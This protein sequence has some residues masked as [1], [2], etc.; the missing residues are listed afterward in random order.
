MSFVNR[1]WSAIMKK[2]LA[3]MF[4]GFFIS[5]SYN[6]RDN[7]HF[8]KFVY[9]LSNSSDSLK[10]NEWVTKN[11][12]GVSSENYLCKDSIRIDSV[13]WGSCFYRDK[14]YSVYGGCRGEFGGSL[15][16]VDEN[17]P[18]YVYYLLSTCAQMV[19][20]RGTVFY[21]TE[22]LAHIDGFGKVTR[23]DDPKKLVKIRRDSLL[24]PWRRE[25]FAHLNGNSVYEKLTYKGHALIDTVGATFD[26][27]FESEK[28]NYL[29]YSGYKATYLGLYNEHKITVLDTL[30][31]YQSYNSEKPGEILDG[32]YHYNYSSTHGVGMLEIKSSGDI[33]VKN[34]TIII[35]F[36][37]KETE[38]LEMGKPVPKSHEDLNISGTYKAD[39]EAGA[40]KGT[41]TLERRKTY[42]FYEWSLISEIG[43]LVA[44]QSAIVDFKQIPK[45]QDE[46]EFTKAHALQ[47]IR[48]YKMSGKEIVY[49]LITNNSVMHY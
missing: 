5:C 12:K 43:K 10:F 26:L 16:F 35:G 4:L 11:I 24:L 30:M 22:S 3:V 46:F 27:F 1:D 19:E 44:G 25:R 42:M 14:N 36:R 17:N 40:F 13:L 34:D 21:I 9:D 28:N 6:N 8:K 38:R 37:Y 41:L 32:I 48:E 15:I 47:A 7:K 18:S 45:G 20:R 39:N 29:I 23:V 49:D 2:Y 33:Y 31:N